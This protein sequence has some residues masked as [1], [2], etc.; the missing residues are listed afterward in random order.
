MNIDLLFSNFELLNTP[1]KIQ[2]LKQAILQLAIQG[3]LVPQDPNDEPASQLLKRIKAEKEK[4]IKEGNP[5][6]E[7]PLP[8]ISS[9]E[10]PIEAPKTWQW[11]RLG[12]ILIFNYGKGIPEN[13]GEGNIPAY[14]ANGIKKYVKKPLVDGPVIIVG[15]KGSVGA[16]N[17]EK[18]SCWPTDVTYYIE[19]HDNLEFDFIYYLLKSLN[20][21]KYGLGIKPGLNRNQVYN[22]FV[23]LPPLEEQKRI[24][25]KI[26]QLFSRAD[27]IESKLKKADEEIVHLDK[28][29]LHQLLESKDGEEFKKNFEF[30]IENFDLLYSDERNVKELRQAILQ[31]AVQGK[32]VP[33]NPNDE[34]ASE[35]IKKI[36]A[37]KQRLI[38][39]WKLKKEKPLPPISEDEIPYKSPKGWKWVRTIEIC[40]YIQRGKS[41]VYSDIK[42]YPV[43]SQKCIQW[44][45]IDISKAR[46]IDPKS[47]EKYESERLL[48]TG[49][50]LWNSTG[51]GTIG[52][53]NL[54]DEKVNTYQLAVAD[55]H[56]TVVRPLISLVNARY[57]CTW[58]SSPHVQN[59]LVDKITGSTKQTELGT[60]T[61]KK[62]LVLL[63][64]LNEQKRIVEK[65][66]ELME[67]FDELESKIVKSKEES[68]R[69]I[70]AILHTSF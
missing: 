47:L 12:N 54:Y 14:G 62:H 31:L 23:P 9:E 55:S 7:K 68:D 57:L 58:F 66:D 22:T 8:P 50:L 26:D 70:D 15:R 65:V 29:A 21:E 5:K 56:V 35:L 44:S 11:V 67:L 69:L 1:Q 25:E 52:R 13:L 33:Q 48:K 18:N 34:P 61:V 63:P 38:K 17:V 27:E 32:L 19:K 39:E 2:K 10:I 6:R 45:G 40:R 16:L 64:P 37:E 36:K 43:L 41:P 53:I 59:V 3:N 30:I 51:D 60:G 49:D 4:L 28:S 20:L 24:V 46:F 42:K